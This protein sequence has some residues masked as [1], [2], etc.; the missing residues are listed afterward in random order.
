MNELST[1]LDNSQELLIDPENPKQLVEE[2]KDENEDQSDG[3]SQS[4]I[5]LVETKSHSRVVAIITVILIDLIIPLMLVLSAISAMQVLGIAFLLLLYIHVFVSNSIKTSF[6]PLKI[7]LSIDFAIN[8]IVFIFAIVAYSVDFSQSEAIHIIGLDFNNII[9][10]KP[11][12]NLVTSLIAMIGQITVL[13]MIGMSDVQE[14]CQI[15]INVF[16]SLGF[17]LFL[18]FFWVVCNAFNASTNMSYVYI[19]ILAYFIYS[20]ISQSITGR[21][22]LPKFIVWIV[23]LYSLLFALFELYMVSD[24]A[25]EDKIESATKYVYIAP[26]ATKAV[27]VVAAVIFAFISAQEMSAPGLDICKPK[28]IPYGLSYISQGLLY[29]AFICA[30]IYGCFYSNYFSLGWMLI[31]F[32]ASFVPFNKTRKF[33][34]PLLTIFF[35]ITF[36]VIILTTFDIIP[37]P[38]DEG[39]ER[40]K[41]FLMLFGLYRYSH[42]FTFS[43]C[44]FFL[45]C[46]FGLI[47]RMIRARVV[48]E[49]YKP[50]EDEVNNETFGQR[51]K[52]GF[53][54]AMTSF[55]LLLDFMKIVLLI[56]SLE[57]YLS[58][59][60]Y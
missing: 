23:M 48:A 46:F 18:E 33:F 5:Q 14:V 17:Q 47:G 36:I 38:P 27:N 30:F 41:E 28:P 32:M 49:T 52:R 34:F 51:F 8:L 20:N 45:N 29:I 50:E 37:E 1:P 43:C 53:K 26:D 35:T 4:E 42:D 13:S 22:V 7:C 24:I 6:T 59:L 11:T 60:Y 12:F 9:S 57:L 55:V 3:E 39:T 16:N 25:Y 19:P 58:L 21:V 2:Q 54:K 15:R 56:I 10:K 40:T 44:G 31:T